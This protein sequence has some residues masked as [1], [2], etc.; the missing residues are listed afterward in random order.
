MRNDSTSG[1]S[2]R[3]ATRPVGIAP[4]GV[5]TLTAA[6]MTVEARTPLHVWNVPGIWFGKQVQRLTTKEPGEDLL[7]IGIPAMNALVEIEEEG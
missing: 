2:C 6:F 4:F 5:L 7:A 1:K 3:P